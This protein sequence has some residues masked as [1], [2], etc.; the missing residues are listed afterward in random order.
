MAQAIPAALMVAGT[1]VSAGGSIIE[2][3]SKASELRFQAAQM[4]AQAG[5]KRATA[6]RSAMDE[7]RQAR[8]AVSRGQAV[9][10]ASGGGA[11]DPTVVNALAG[12]SGEGEYRALTA[13]YNGEEEAQS[14]EAQAA[15]NRRGAKS[16][17]T[18]GLLKAGGTILSAG[19]SLYDRF[20]K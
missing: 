4:D 1:A 5:L 2:A 15:A 12:I 18:A 8:L 6:Q 16:V 11:S 14:L 10:A 19:S 3:N 13:L 20:G 17:K 9:A 7:K